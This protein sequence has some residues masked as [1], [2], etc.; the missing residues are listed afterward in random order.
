MQRYAYV[1]AVENVNLNVWPGLMVPEFHW[2]LFAT[3]VCAMESLFVHATVAPTATTS[4]F[5][6]KA[7]VERIDAPPGMLALADAVEVELGVVVVVDAED[8]LDD[9]LPQPAAASRLA[10]SPVAIRIF[11]RAIQ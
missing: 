5:A 6:P 7:V 1:P 2:P 3:D 10:A 4:G 8:G 9:E 11:R